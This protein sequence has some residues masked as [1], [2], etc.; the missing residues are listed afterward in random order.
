[1]AEG[2]AVGPGP[3]DLYP[4]LVC[5]LHPFLAENGHHEELHNNQQRG[6]GCHHAISAGCLHPSPYSGAP[7]EHHRLLGLLLQTQEMD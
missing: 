5:H 4:S 3:G 6:A 1:M 7:A 2:T